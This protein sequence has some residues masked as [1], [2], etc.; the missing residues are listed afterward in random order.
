MDNFIMQ[1]DSKSLPTTENA[2]ASPPRHSKCFSLLAEY[3]GK[4]RQKA[5]INYYSTT[6]LISMQIDA[7]QDVDAARGVC[8]LE[9]S[10]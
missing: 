4:G 9:S 7:L 3:I 6:A 5:H 2:I 1:T 8:A 10:S